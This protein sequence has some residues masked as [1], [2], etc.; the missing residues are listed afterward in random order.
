[1]EKIVITGSTGL[2]GTKLVTNLE[3]EHNIYPTYNTNP[4]KHPNAVKLDLLDSLSLETTLQTIKPDVIIHSAAM[5]HVDQCEQNPK[6][7]EKINY[8]STK[9][10]TT[11]AKKLGSHLIFISTD[12]VFDGEKGNYKETD[13]PNPINV[14]GKTKYNAEQF[15]LE[16]EIESTIIRPSV[17]YGNT[18]ASG[19]TN[20]VL[21]IIDQL[22]QEKQINIIDDQTISPTYNQN[23]A[24]MIKEVVERKITGIYHLSGATQINRLDFTYKIAEIFDLDSHLINSV[25]SNTMNWTAKRPPNSSLNIGKAN[26]CLENK[27]EIAEASLKRL[28]IELTSSE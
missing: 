16:Q 12:Y 2:L 17:I 28:K 27:P 8:Q 24:N 25:S 10:I 20:F 5:T 9:T 15:I 19:K 22:K 26:K 1:M 23:L 4:S 7:A 21:W 11:N 18:S 3:T 14:Y 13:Q 6:L